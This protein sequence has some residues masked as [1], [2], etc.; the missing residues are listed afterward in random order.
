[1]CGDCQRYQEDKA[2]KKKE[3]VCFMCLD[4]ASESSFR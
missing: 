4:I 1:M 3:K 2:K